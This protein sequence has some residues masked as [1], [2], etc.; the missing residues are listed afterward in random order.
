MVGAAGFEPARPFGQWGLS[1]SRLTNVTPRPRTIHSNYDY[2]K[3]GL[4]PMSNDSDSDARQ[5]QA[6]VRLE[7]PGGFEPPNNGFAVRCLTTWLRRREPGKKNCWS[8]KRDSNPPPRPW[9]GRALPLSYSRKPAPDCTTP[10]KAL[11]RSSGRVFAQG[12]GGVLGRHGV[13]E[14]A[15]APLVARHVGELG[16]DLEVPVEVLERAVAQRRR[17]QHEIEGR[18]VEHAIH[19]PQELA[20][21]LGQSPQLLH[22]GLLERGA[23]ASRQDP[24]LEGKARREG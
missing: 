13:D 19:A 22:A 5:I 4:L 14:E 11:A 1:P 9:Q 7:A 17:V 8:G 6:V 15:A 16:N 24:R 21:Q 3:P 2:A 12:G 23:M 10:S 20:E 18:A